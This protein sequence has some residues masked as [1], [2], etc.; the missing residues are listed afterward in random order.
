LSRLKGRRQSPYIFTLRPEGA[1]NI[2]LGSWVSDLCFESRIAQGIQIWVQNNQLKALLST[3][4]FKK[5][6]SA[7]KN[8]QKIER[9]VDF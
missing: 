9:F 7:Q 1:E 3:I 5:R 6:F 2:P 4:F 8:H